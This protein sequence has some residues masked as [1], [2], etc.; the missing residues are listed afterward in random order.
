MGKKVGSE[1]MP[2]TDNFAWEFTHKKPTS[3]VLE[4]CTSDCNAKPAVLF[5]YQVEVCV[6]LFNEFFC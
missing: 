3:K 2:L 5:S 1:R 6:I 4:G